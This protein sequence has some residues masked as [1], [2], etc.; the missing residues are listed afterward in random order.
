MSAIGESSYCYQ[1]TCAICLKAG[2]SANNKVTISFPAIIG[3]KEIFSW[4]HQQCFKRINAAWVPFNASL[5]KFHSKE[6]DLKHMQAIQRVYALLPKGK[7]ILEAFQDKQ[8][9]ENGLK[10]MLLEALSLK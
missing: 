8:I 10:I 2:E 1:D 6:L 9:G 3:K 7:T 5:T 4:A